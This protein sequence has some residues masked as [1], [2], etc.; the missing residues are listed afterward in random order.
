MRVEINGKNFE[1]EQDIE[2][3]VQKKL[4][5]LT[6]KLP[7]NVREAAHAIVTLKHSPKKKSERFE[8]DI[9][10]RLPPKEEL[11]A[12]ESTVNIFA[13]VDIVESKL[14]SQLEKYRGKFSKKYDRKG[15]LQKIRRVA[16]RDF[17]GKQN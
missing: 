10:L 2:K 14:E 16:D 4:T 17:W 9:V 6:R 1:L 3:Y 5:K 8:A 15:A 13:A 12:K 7:K 11:I